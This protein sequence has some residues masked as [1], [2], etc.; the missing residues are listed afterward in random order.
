MGKHRQTKACEI[1]K[2]V[3]VAV[4]ER[5]GHACVLCGKH[6]EQ[7]YANAHFIPRS[8]G[9]LG[10]EENILTLCAYCHRM[11]DQTVLRSKIKEALCRY[12]ESKHP[13]WHEQSLYYKKYGGMS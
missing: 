1:P 13:G 11:F 2:A 10:V 9:G 12:L 6:V 7:F 5:D 4:Y 8:Q 3:K